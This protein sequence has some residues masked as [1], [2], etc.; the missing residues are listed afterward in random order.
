MDRNPVVFQDFQYTDMSEPFG[1]ACAEDE[2][3]FSRALQRGLGWRRSRS[4]TPG[5]DQA[6]KYE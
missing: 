1:G 4:S 2:R 3:N 5:N 6:A